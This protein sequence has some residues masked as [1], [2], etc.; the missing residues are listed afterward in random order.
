M[1]KASLDQMG[2]VSWG[3]AMKKI[4]IM[5]FIEKGKLVKKLKKGSRIKKKN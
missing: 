4:I 3:C 5:S 2:E 1:V